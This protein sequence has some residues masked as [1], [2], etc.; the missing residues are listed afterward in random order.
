[1]IKL[2]SL[3]TDGVVLQQQQPIRVWGECAPRTLVKAEI[4]GKSAYAKS[5]GDGSFMLQLPPLNAGGPF[6]LTVSLPDIP[7]ETVTL[8]DVLT[9]E[10]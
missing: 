8:H 3:F 6:E 10:V 1:M 4:S 7:G 5:S 2:A 9:G